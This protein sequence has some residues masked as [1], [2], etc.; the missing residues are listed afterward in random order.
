MFSGACPG[1]DC[2]SAAH[3][4]TVAAVNDATSEGNHVSA[5]SHVVSSSDARYDGIT[6]A[7]ISV[8][9]RDRRLIFVA[10]TSPFSPA[11]G[12]AGLDAICAADA[13]KPT[14]DTYR[15]MVAATTRLPCTTANCAG[16]SA[17]HVSWVL[18]PATRYYAVDGNTLIGQTNAGAGIF[19]F[20]LTSAWTGA[21]ASH[22]WTGMNADWTVSA[23]NC[24]N[25]TSTAT[26]GRNG[27][28]G[29]TNSGA[30]NGGLN[31][32]TTTWPSIICVAQ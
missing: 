1:V 16:G 12:L 2:W 24:S 27:A 5:I 29:F 25:W 9:I 19:T 30:I 23:D 20:P 11:V 17:E 15:A 32:C 6:V 14:T 3:T 28:Y 7:G 31:A 18:A 4:V 22:P 13:N 26:N 8:A 21:G 10:G